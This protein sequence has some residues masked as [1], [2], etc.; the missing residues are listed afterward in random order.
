M[1]M[2]TIAGALAVAWSFAAQPLVAKTKKID[3]RTTDGVTAV[4]GQWKYHDV[5]IVEVDGKGP[6]G[7][8]N[9]TYNIEPRAEKVVFDDRDWPTIAPETLKDRRSTGQVCLVGH[10]FTTV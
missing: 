5:K 3:L 10:H 8:P 9:K 7:K 6:D 1:R 4:K 2:T